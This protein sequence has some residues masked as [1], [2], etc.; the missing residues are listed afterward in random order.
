[1]D[2]SVRNPDHIINIG[3]DLSFIDDK[4]NLFVVSTGSS[5][6]IRSRRKPNSLLDIGGTNVV[7]ATVSP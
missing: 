1:M 7:S 5:S 4:V 6:D 2:D 3:V